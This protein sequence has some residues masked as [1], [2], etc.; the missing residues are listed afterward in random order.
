MTQN[1]NNS[2][3]HDGIEVKGIVDLKQGD[4][5][6]TANH[7]RLFDAVD[8]YFPLKIRPRNTSKYMPHQ[9]KRECERRL[10]RLK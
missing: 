5:V 2:N 3:A 10:R 4:K 8:M 7:I 1:N 6:L 9:G